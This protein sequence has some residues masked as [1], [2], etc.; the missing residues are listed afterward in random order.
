M[1]RYPVRDLSKLANARA[2]P[3]DTWLFDHP[4]AFKM[5]PSSFPPNCTWCKTKLTVVNDRW[6]QCPK[7]DAP[8]EEK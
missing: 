6:R 7:C 8:E 4:G 5:K 1:K 3:E 2:V